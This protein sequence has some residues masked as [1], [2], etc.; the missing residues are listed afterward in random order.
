[1]NNYLAILCVWTP[2]D[3]SQQIR[4]WD[5]ACIRVNDADIIRRLRK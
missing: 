4:G 3:G 2:H 1:M 5:I